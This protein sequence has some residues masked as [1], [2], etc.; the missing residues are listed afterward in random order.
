M[1]SWYCGTN[2][3]D[4]LSNPNVDSYRTYS[5]DV[6]KVYNILGIDAARQ[7]L[8]KEINDVIH[9]SGNYVNYRHISL[10]CDFM[11]NKGILM[12]IDRFGINRDNDIGPLAK[13]FFW[14]NNWTDI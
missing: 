2:L 13:Y 14:G 9:F 6:I 5:N 10:L 4:I 11:T 8:I 12:S 3:I 7:L 1:G